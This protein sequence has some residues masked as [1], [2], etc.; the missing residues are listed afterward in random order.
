MQGLFCAAES[1][2][3]NLNRPSD[4]SDAYINIPISLGQ[5]HNSWFSYDLNTFYHK[6]SNLGVKKVLVGTIHVLSSCFQ[7]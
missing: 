7:I 6:S 3:P 1:N 5:V 2:G 4:L